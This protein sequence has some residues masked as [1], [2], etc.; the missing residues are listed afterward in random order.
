MFLCPSPARLQ[1]MASPVVTNSSQV[2]Q[3]FT[4]PRECPQGL[5]VS[6]FLENWNDWLLSSHLYIPAREEQA[7]PIQMAVG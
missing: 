3:D 1:K 7:N 6:P 5:V 2:L 4:R